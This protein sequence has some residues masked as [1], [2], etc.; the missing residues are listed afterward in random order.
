M[1]LMWGEN[2]DLCSALVLGVKI[3]LLGESLKHEEEGRLQATC[4]TCLCNWR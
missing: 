2:M 4:E 1:K 3:T